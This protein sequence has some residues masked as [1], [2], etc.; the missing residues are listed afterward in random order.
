MNTAILKPR[1]CLIAPG[2]L[3]VPATQGGA[4]ETLMTSLADENER[5]QRL[6]LT[7]VTPNRIIV[8][9]HILI[10]TLSVFLTHHLCVALNIDGEMHY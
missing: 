10:L 4:I 8:L 7:V 5:Q 3:P 6:D 2:L 1:I 9:S